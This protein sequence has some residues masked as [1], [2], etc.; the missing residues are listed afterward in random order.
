MKRG[1]EFVVGLVVLGSLALVIGGALWLSG[2]G[3][4]SQQDIYV[5]RFRTVGGLGV[6]APVTLRGVKVG[7]VEAIRLARDEWV[8]AELTVDKTVTLPRKPAVISAS[9]SLFGEWAANIIPFEPLPDDPNVRAALVESDTTGGDA[10]PGATLPDIGQLTAQASR[11]AGDVADVTQRIRGVFDTTA[12]HQ[13]QQSV[14]DL[15]S[16][17]HRVA[18]FTDAQADR[19]DHVSKSVATSADAFAGIARSFEHTVSRMDT[20][21]NANQLQEILNNTR[22]AS[23]DLKD[24]AHDFRSVM[25]AAHES[26]GSLVRTLQTADSLLSRIERG[27]GTLGRLAADSALY[28]ETTR[29]VTELRQLLADIK[30]NPKRY[31]KVSV[32]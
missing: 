9:N 27:Q 21:T 11:I 30:A 23:A 26:Q 2:R 17:S 24:A 13:L 25:A 5:A 32:F 4:N 20:A 6:G 18:K 7:R 15:A 19:L 10:W 12:L 16:I 28:V 22:S 14:L 31:F 3:M 8:E 1:N 29:T